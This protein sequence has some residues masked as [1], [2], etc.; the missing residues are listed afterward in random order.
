MPAKNMPADWQPP[1]DAW[2]A[3]FADELSE[4][5]FGYFGCQFAGQAA[6][7]EFVETFLAAIGGGANAPS[8]VTRARHPDASG[9][10]NN[11]FIA[12]WPGQDAFKTWWQDAGFGRWFDND[13]R[14]S[15]SFGLWREVYVV[16][17]ERFETLFSSKD[18]TGA[19]TLAEPFGAPVQ[20]HNYWGG[21]RDRIDASATDE[22]AP[23][24]PD[25]HRQVNLRQTRRQRV[26]VALPHNICLIRSG[27]NW[28]A[29]D[30]D[31]LS[32]YS[33]EVRP[34]LTAGMAFLRDN[35]GETGCLSCRL[36]DETALDGTE[37]SQSFGLAAFT[38]MRHLEGW[39]KTHPTHL[40]IFESFLAMVQKREQ[41]PKLKLWHEVL[42]AD[43]R[44]SLCEYTNCHPRTG[45]L[46]WFA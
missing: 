41:P 26:R 8:F 19:A 39:S 45:Y 6:P 28:G 13:D 40:R 11:V 44:N 29:C 9:Y 10:T 37:A 35:P 20:E 31:E 16:P 15:A 7:A 22:F 4:V 36:M 3:A 17:V 25:A 14:L 24:Q 2:K 43:S 23:S 34:F 21:M 33:D 32:A 46:P 27:Q 1:V 42:I 12:Y 38:S 18:P 5:V 30:D